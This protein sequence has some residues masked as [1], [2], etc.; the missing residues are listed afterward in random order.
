MPNF[1]IFWI[2]TYFG[3]LIAAFV[4]P[5]FGLLTYLFE[6][7]LRPK[8]HWW[9]DNELPD[10]RWTMMVATVAI[11]AFLMRRGSLPPTSSVTMSCSR[12]WISCRHSWP[13]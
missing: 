7:Y 3:G 9:G 10:W 8:L 1:T 13:P 12:A 5:L 11:V 4:N 2:V 6:Y